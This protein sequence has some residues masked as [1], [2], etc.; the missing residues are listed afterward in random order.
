MCTVSFEKLNKENPLYE[1]FVISN[2]VLAESGVFSVADVLKKGQA[3]NIQLTKDAV[4]KR[5][6]VLIRLGYLGRICTSQFFVM[7]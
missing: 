5:L 6:M 3:N 7:K 2:L 1:S 4:E